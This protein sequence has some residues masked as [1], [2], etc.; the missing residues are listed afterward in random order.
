M[1]DNFY[2]N[3]IDH[4]M[5][6][7]SYNRVIRNE[8]GEPCD[9]VFL[10]VNPAFEKY[11]GLKAENLIG[12]RVTEVLPEMT[13]DTFNFISH[14]GNIG[15]NGGRGEFEQYSETLGKWYKTQVYS[16]EK[17][18]FVINF[19]EITEQE[20]LKKNLYDQTQQ[21][22]NFFHVNLD[23]LCIADVNGNFI[24]VNKAWQDTLGYTILELKETKYLDLVHPEDL[25]KTK[26]AML[27]LK[28]Q[29]K[30]LNFVNRFR[31]KN[32]NYRSIEWRS[33]SKDNFIYAAARDITEKIRLSEKLAYSE[34]ILRQVLDT[35]PIQIFWKDLDLKYLGCNLKFAKSVG[36]DAPEDIVGKTDYDLTSTEIADFYRLDDYT[37]IESQRPKINSEEFDID[38]E[39]NDL[40]IKTT[41]IPL[42]DE[43]NNVY[44]VMGTLE[45]ITEKKEAEDALKESQQRYEQLAKISHSVAWEMDTNGVYTYV[46]DVVR[47]VYGYEPEEVIGKMTFYDFVPKEEKDKRKKMGFSVINNK[48]KVEDYEQKLRN[49]NNKEVWVLTNGFPILDINGDLVAY[50]GIDIDITQRKMIENQMQHLSFHD[51]L[52]G[53]YNRRYFETEIKRL[54]HPDNLPLSMVMI[55]VNGL[56]LVNDAFGHEVGDELIKKVAEAMKAVCRQEDVIARVGGDEFII[57]LPKTSSEHV[58]KVMDR[59]FEQIQQQKVEGIDVTVSYGYETKERKYQ[60]LNDLLKKAETYMYKKK[61]K[62]K[63]DLRNRVIEQIQQQLFKKFPHEKKHAE[64]V[65]YFSGQIGKA[66]ELEEEEVEKLKMIGKL[67]DIGKIAIED[68][69]IHQQAGYK[70]EN[71]SEADWQEFKRHAE[72][73]YI[74]LTSS[75]EYT[76]FAEDVL[77]HHEHYDGTGYPKGLK[78][79][80]IPLNARIL[81][82][83]DTFADL[84]AHKQNKDAYTKKEA[85]EEIQKGAGK[86]FDPEI[87]EVFVKEVLD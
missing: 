80:E 54:D 29:N 57:L 17:N 39:G 11:T 16:P 28:N 81:A 9:Y 42:Y 84:V 21:L 82:V 61:T 41:K 32:G 66:M 87:V 43:A 12:K 83:A 25:E 1:G 62:N 71:F 7:Y 44:G 35:M 79:E 27:H 77:H 4:S 46:N 65:A 86:A 8:K 70:K 48:E 20:N 2:K 76:I 3:I 63:V 56:K 5:V 45:D 50:R 60:S 78:K 19:I 85:I 14:F 58:Q 33:N 64:H 13:Q 75:N 68:H 15:I 40:W 26:N 31:C 72:V 59:I 10:E 69:I 24:K 22:E 34:Q 30:V 49:K 37:V 6:G 38:E 51:H 74:I 53:L 23:L 67:H 36:I 18:H 52:T 55:D 47:T 73:S